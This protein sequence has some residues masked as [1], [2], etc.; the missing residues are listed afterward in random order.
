VDQI[1]LLLQIGLYVALAN[2]FVLGQFLGLCP[3]IGVTK[4]TSSAFGM[5]IA[6]TFVMTMASVVTYC[7]YEYLLVPYGLVDVLA[8]GSF[9]LVIAALVQL[10]EMIIRKTSPGLYQALGIYLPLITTNCAILGI[11]ILSVQKK[12]GYVEDIVYSAASAAGF[13]LALILFAG[14]RERLAMRN[15]PR[16]LAGIPIGLVTAGIL[17]MAFMGFAGLGAS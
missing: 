1:V 3:F 7:I 5:G 15:V 14:V 4:K 9:I 12:L 6:V 17:A 10:V 11:A 16:G 13:A 2:N 8:T